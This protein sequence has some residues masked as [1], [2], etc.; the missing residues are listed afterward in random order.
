MIFKIKGIGRI[1]DSQIEMNGIT[2]IAGENNT[3][4]STFGKT[5]YCIFN[6]FQ[7]TVIAI[8][9]ER[10]NDIRRI[11][12]NNISSLKISPIVLEHLSVNIIDEVYNTIDEISEDF[13]GNII[14]PTILEKS[15]SKENIKKSTIIDLVFAIKRSL[16]VSDDEIQKIVISHYFINEFNEKINHVNKPNSTGNISLII[17]SKNVDVT[18]KNNECIKFFDNVGIRHNAIYMDTPFVLDDVQSMYQIYISS[19]FPLNYNTNINHRRNLCYRLAKGYSSN[20]VIEEV[21][22]NQKIKSLLANI[23]KVINGEFREDKESLMFMEN[24][25]RK[26]IPLSNVSAGIKTFLILKRLLELGEIKERNILIL[27]EP[28]I[29]L[30]PAW[31]LQ[32]AEILVLLQKEFNLT[33]LLNTHSPYFLNAVEVYGKKHGI[34]DHINFY[35]VESNGDTSDV[36][37]VTDMIDIIYKQL[38]EP[39][40]KLEDTAYGD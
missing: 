4:K 1:Q 18:I 30:H 14:M 26:P 11:M 6:A 17:K 21:I 20:T 29:H 22:I 7:N 32:F 15:T 36:R 2:V 24:G 25:L 34:K 9:N 12:Y 8:R 5:L 40:Q 28:E 39:F 23:D 38:A 37:D 3:G 31:Q 33:I 10:I 35:L 16:E 27:D 13:I 19:N